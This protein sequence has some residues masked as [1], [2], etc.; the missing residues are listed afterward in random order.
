MQLL[1]GSRY[2]K[3]DGAFVTGASIATL[4]EF[5]RPLPPFAA[6]RKLTPRRHRVEFTA[7]ARG[8]ISLCSSGR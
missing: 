1:A 2:D 8:P 5:S 6:R 4:V 7:Q 3:R